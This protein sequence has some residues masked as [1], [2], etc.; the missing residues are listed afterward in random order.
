M[1]GH[2]AGLSIPGPTIYFK[3]SDCSDVEQVLRATLSCRSSF[4][5][6]LCPLQRTL[7][8]FASALIKQPAAPDAIPKKS[9][10]WR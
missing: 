10:S 8:E 9:R 2:V 5:I 1:S 7:L 3:L 6:Q 4:L